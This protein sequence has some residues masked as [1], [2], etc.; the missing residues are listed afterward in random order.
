[1]LDSGPQQIDKPSSQPI[2]TY[3][4]TAKPT[5][6]GINQS[7]NQSINFKKSLMSASRILNVS[8]TWYPSANI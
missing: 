6:T 5:T 2:Q 3:Q 8:Y 4:K 7:I 1:M